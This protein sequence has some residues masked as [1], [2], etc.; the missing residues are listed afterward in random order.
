MRKAIAAVLGCSLLLVSCRSY[1]AERLAS[2]GYEQLIARDFS[3]AG[4]S[5]RRQAGKKR[6]TTRIDTTNLLSLFLE[7]DYE[8][9]SNSA[10]KPLVS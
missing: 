9:W 1:Q 4:A 3:A 10:K 5:L 7:G 6:T 2:E 8:G